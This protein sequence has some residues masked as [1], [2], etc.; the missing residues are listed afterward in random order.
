MG[1]EECARISKKDVTNAVAIEQAVLAS[2]AIYKAFHNECPDDW[3]DLGPRGQ[4]ALMDLVKYIDDAA[5]SSTSPAKVDAATERAERERITDLLTAIHVVHR[6]VGAPGDWGY[7]C[8]TGDAARWLYDTTRLLAACSNRLA[9]FPAPNVPIGTL[10]RYWTGVRE[11]E[12]KTGKTR[13]E[14]QNM[15]GTP[16]V[17][18]EGQ[19]GCIAMSHVEV[20]EEVPA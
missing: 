6:Y 17:W 18:V 10:V 13:S 11:G 16:V 15:H 19:A 1:Y 7:G 2:R 8:P 9:K 14:V 20:M 12:G 5:L 3:R 4:V